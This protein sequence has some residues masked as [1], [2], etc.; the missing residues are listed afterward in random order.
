MTWFRLDD[1]GT[2]TA[3]SWQSAILLPSI[4]CDL[5]PVTGTFGAPSTQ[6]QKEHAAELKNQM[7]G[8]EWGSCCFLLVLLQ[9]GFHSLHVVQLNRVS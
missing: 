2:C 9:A 8:G 6:E 4:G 3:S 1:W 5:A 7:K